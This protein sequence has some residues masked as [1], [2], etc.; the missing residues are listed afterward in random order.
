MY[1]GTPAPILL[2]SVF[3][4]R[5][6]PACTGEPRARRATSIPACTGEPGSCL[7]QIDRVYPRVYGG[8]YPHAE[9][10][11]GVTLGLSPRVRGNPKCLLY[12]GRDA[13]KVYPRV[14]GGTPQGEGR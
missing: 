6:I 14:Y 3:A 5:S 11:P 12:I 2:Q 4:M 10:S 7:D 9:E 1:G 8:T 13:K